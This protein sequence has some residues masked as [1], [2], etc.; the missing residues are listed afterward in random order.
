MS[1]RDHNKT[2]GVMHLIFGGMNAMALLANFGFIQRGGIADSLGS[3]Q[4]AALLRLRPEVEPA[5]LVIFLLLFSVPSLIAGYGMLKRKSWAQGAGVIA[6][7]ASSLNPPL[8]T[9]LCVYSLWFLF[10]EGK[11]FYDSR[12]EEGLRAAARGA[13]FYEDEERKARGNGQTDYEPPNQQPDW[14][15]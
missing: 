1:P 10:G 7:I 15:D 12:D 14:R 3:L 9:A 2:L 6:A 5:L 13:S 11:H 4:V 8:G